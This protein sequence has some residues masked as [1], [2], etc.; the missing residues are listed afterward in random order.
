M[1]PALLGGAAMGAVGNLLGGGARKRAA[2]AQADALQRG[3]DMQMQMFREGQAATQPYRQAGA[4]ALGQFQGLMSTQG[5]GDFYNEYMQS[6]MFQA[7]QGQAEEANLRAASATGGLRTGQTG[8][9]LAAIAPQL[10]M[11][12]YQQRLGGL[13]SLI[14]T[15]AGAAGQTASIAPQVGSQMA[16]MIGQQGAAQGAADTAMQGAFAN[17]L[18]Q[19]GGLGMYAGQGG[20]EGLI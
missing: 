18:G 8:A 7:L 3:Q 19:L 17:T 11:Q 4:D 1:L 12:G 16:N 15:G 2:Q 6:P 14:G 13:Q 5:Q 10:A 20:F 9:A